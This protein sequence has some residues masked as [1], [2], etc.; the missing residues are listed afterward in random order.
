MTFLHTSSKSEIFLKFSQAIQKTMFSSLNSFFKNSCKDIL[1][2]LDQKV[3][4]C[5]SGN[6]KKG[7]NKG[8]NKQKGTEDKCQIK[9][10]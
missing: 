7:E 2:V 8:E 5:V 3:F 9:G 1:K 6:R 10:K 4:C